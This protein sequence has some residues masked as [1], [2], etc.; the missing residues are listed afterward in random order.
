M[1]NGMEGIRTEEFVAEFEVLSRTE[2]NHK[3]P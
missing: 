1:S 3:K 2:E